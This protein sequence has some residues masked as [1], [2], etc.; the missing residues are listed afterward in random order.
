MVVKRPCVYLLLRSW[1]TP[2][3]SQALNNSETLRLLASIELACYKCRQAVGDPRMHSKIRRKIAHVIK[4]DRRKRHKRRR[5][6]D[7]LVDAFART[8]LNSQMDRS[9]SNALRADGL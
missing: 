3:L 6:Q 2:P 8:D 9:D 5:D 1:L 7:A 4:E